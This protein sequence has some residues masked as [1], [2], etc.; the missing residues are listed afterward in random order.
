MICGIIRYRIQS[1][2]NMSGRPAPGQSESSGKAELQ[3]RRR[4]TANQVG[5]TAGI[6]NVDDLFVGNKQSVCILV[7]LGYELESYCSCK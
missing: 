6:L 4:T 5:V 1:G 3:Q 2:N 7:Y